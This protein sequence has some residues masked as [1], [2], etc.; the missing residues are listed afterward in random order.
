MSTTLSRRTMLKTGALVTA[1]AASGVGTV[2]TAFAADRAGSK[3]NW[4]HTVDFGEQYFTRMKDIVESIRRNEMGLIGDIT[5]RM[6]EAI[7]KGGNGFMQAQ[8][9]HMGYIEFKEENKGNPRI[10]KSSLAWGGGDYDKMKSGDVLVTNYVNEDVKA[11][12]D[13]GVYVVGVP[14]NYVDNEWAPR[15]FVSPNPNN[16]LLGDVSNVILKS[17]IPYHQGIVDCPEVPEMKICP[18]AANSLNTIYWMMQAEVANKLKNKKAK[19]VELSLAYI[20]TI[21]ERVSEAYRLQKDMMFDA[22]PTVAKMIGGGGHY[23]V[24]SDHEGVE[25]ES[26]GVA[27]G[28]MMTNA[29]RKDMKKGDVH[30]VATIEPDSPKIVDEAKKAKE[31]G[32]FV[33]AIAPG[34]SLKIRQYADLFIDNLSPEGGGM[35]DIA[36][37]SGKVSTAGG[38][39]NNWLMWIF[40]AQFIDEMVRRGWI[41][42]FWLGYYQVGGKEYDEAVRPFFFKQGF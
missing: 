12:K 32:M 27:M 10:L 35:F 5:S 31:T 22:A 33:I 28:P 30:L 18:S 24:T 9:G 8:A 7:Q 15:G 16:W 14:V 38:V 39:L 13:K 23:H 41:P 26:N 20:D 2:R 6:A 17:Y 25:S 3:Y 37:I 1:G 40:T 19:Q 36:G 29:F 11:A 21:L 42:W 34:N 4:G